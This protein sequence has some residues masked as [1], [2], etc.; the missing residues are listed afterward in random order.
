MFRLFQRLVTALATL[1]ICAVIFYLVSLFYA[2]VG[3]VATK[4]TDTP[5]TTAGVVYVMTFKNSAP[6]KPATS[7]GQ[8]PN[9]KSS[10]SRNESQQ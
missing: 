8:R 7:Q 4:I 6:P 10:S 5:K 3:A 1:G 2:H 9:P